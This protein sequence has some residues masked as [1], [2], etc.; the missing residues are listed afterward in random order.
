MT[1][2]EFAELKEKLNKASDRELGAIYEHMSEKDPFK[3]PANRL[4]L[5]S[6]VRAKAIKHIEM[7]F[8]NGLLTAQ[9]NG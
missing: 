5:P 1:N 8:R 6:A 2:R 9:K 3:D 4:L 7:L